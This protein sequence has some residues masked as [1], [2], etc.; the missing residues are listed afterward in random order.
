MKNC[1]YATGIIRV[2]KN[3]EINVPKQMTTP[4]GIQSASRQCQNGSRERKA[5]EQFPF[6][7]SFSLATHSI[8]LEATS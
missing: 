8:L 6:H 5:C 7:Q 2:M 1:Q 3:T 4:I